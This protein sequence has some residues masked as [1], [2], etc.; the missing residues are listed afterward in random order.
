MLVLYIT[1]P[2]NTTLIRC[3]YKNFS[4]WDHSFERKLG[5]HWLKFLRQHHV[6][7]VIQGPGTQLGHHCSHRLTS[8]QRSQG[9]SSHSVAYKVIQYLINIFQ[10][11]PHLPWAKTRAIL[12][13]TSSYAFSRMKVLKSLF[14][15]Q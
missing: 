10:L 11:L 8:V 7:V 12:Q 5:F 14:N 4:Q 9:I 6:V 1:G 13:T 2:C 3:C 15:F